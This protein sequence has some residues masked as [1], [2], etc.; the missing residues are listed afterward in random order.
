MR[1]MAHHPLLYEINTRCWLNEFST[2]AGTEIHL[3]NV[4]E[5]EFLRWKRLGFTHI[6][7]MGV[8]TTGPRAR[9]HSLNDP[10]LRQKYSEVLPDW[11]ERDVLGSPYAV[12][13]YRVAIRL[14]GE[15][16]L[17]RFRERL[18]EQG[19]KLILDF[20]PNHLGID[21]DWIV[22]R[23]ELLVQTSAHAPE[24][25]RRKTREG[26]RWFAH[27]KDPNFP[28]WVDTVQLDYRRAET[29]AAMIEGLQAISNLC[30]GVR[31]DMAMLLLNEVMTKVWGAPAASSAIDQEFWPEAIDRVKQARPDFLFLAE[32]YW[33]LESRLQEMGFDYTYE[34]E[35]YD[36]LI[37]RNHGALQ[38]HL[39]NKPPDYLRRSIHF[40]EN[41]DEPR[42]ASTLTL[43]EHRAAALATLG[44]PGMRLLHEGQLTGLRI[45]ALVHLGR[46][47]REGVD[48][49]VATFYENLL[50]VLQNTAVG[51]GQ[52]A[53]LR[54]FAVW[55]GNST[56]ENF[57]IVQWWEAPK[58]FD[59]VV[60]NLTGHQSQCC[61]RIISVG[62]AEHL[63]RMQDLLGNQ[64]YERSSDHLQQ[65]GL[66]LDVAA[67][68][69]QLFHC[70]CIY[71]PNSLTAKNAEII[72]KSR[73]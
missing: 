72:K 4:P 29:R 10:G 63:W 45:Q 11:Q 65:H 12:A 17:R 5:E 56:T 2:Q 24:S 46:R 3:G 28:A 30:D 73:T 14:G 58:A 44:L 6:W 16:G 48:P 50:A 47:A 49:E 40:L 25:F 54:P 31:C 21:H 7:L 33:G 27:G 59:L 53:V 41:H 15:A 39:L 23:P 62:I 61:V 1:E 43:A 67:H 57:V 37:A 9:R 71:K 32:A 20:V 51:R 66:F 42:I 18:C 35:S 60:V 70:Q 13:E 52:F 22:E 19:L 36:Y 26:N 64:S 55:D 38:R 68:A 8:W 69:T 34:K